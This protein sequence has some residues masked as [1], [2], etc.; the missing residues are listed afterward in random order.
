M[1]RLYSDVLH[2]LGMGLR[3]PCSLPPNGCWAICDHSGTFVLTGGLFTA[4]QLSHARMY[5]WTSCFIPDHQQTR[6]KLWYVL[7]IPWCLPTTVSWNAY[8]VCTWKSDGI[9]TSGGSPG[10]LLL[11]NR[12][13][14]DTRNFV[15]V[16]N[17]CWRSLVEMS[18]GSSPVISRLISGAVFGSVA[19]V[20]LICAGLNAWVTKWTVC[21]WSSTG[22]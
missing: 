12:V 4:Q 16:S 1:K 10:F 2:F 21:S 7:S 3:C 5:S 11:L 13:S 6:L 9:T 15:L 18:L 22:R 14:S 17:R 8:I 19:W 20:D